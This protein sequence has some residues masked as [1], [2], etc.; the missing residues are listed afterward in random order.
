MV[1][2]VI[3]KIEIEGYDKTYRASCGDEGGG[4]FGGA[5]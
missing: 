5:G 1:Y 2:V 3:G 4:S